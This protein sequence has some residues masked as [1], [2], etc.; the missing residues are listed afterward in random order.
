MFDHCKTWRFDD[1]SVLS[2][3]RVL[4]HQ[5]RFLNIIFVIKPVAAQTKEG[6]EVRL[7]LPSFT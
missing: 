4:L 3:T 7:K 5:M 1:R 2:R 6:S